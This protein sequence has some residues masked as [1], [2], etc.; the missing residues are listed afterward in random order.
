[1]KRK[2][3][4]RFFSFL[5]GGFLFAATG[6]S[7]QTI[8]SRETNLAS[9]VSGPGF[10]NNVDQ[11]LQNP[12]GIAFQPRG[13]FFI[14][15]TAS[16]H[17]SVHDAN[18]AGARPGSFILPKP[19]A[20]RPETPTGIVADAS[21]FLEG[22]EVFQPFITATEDGDI[23]VWGTDS[24]GD[25]PPNATLVV[26]HSQSGAVYTGLAILTPNCC[27]PFLGVANFHSGQIESFTARFDLLAPAGSFT[28]PNLPAGF[29]PYGMQ[30][31]GNQLFI[32]YAVQDAAKQNPVFGAGNG[33]VSIFDLAGNFQRRFATGGPLNAPWGITQA[34]PNFGPFRND[35]LIGNF[36][37]GIVNAFDPATGAFIGQI[38]DGDGNVIVNEGLHGL[39]FRPDGF[40]DRNTL[41]FTAGI[42]NGLDG[43]FGKITPGLVSTTR[44]SA[45]PSLIS[46][47][48]PITVT[49]SAGP[50]NPGTPTGL[51][52]VND[53]GVSI[54]DVGITN[55]VIVFPAVL[56]AVGTHIFEAKYSGDATFLPSSSQT[57]VQVTGAATQL[58]LAA[59]ATA[60]PGSAVTLTASLR[61]GGGTPTGLI[62]FHDGNVSLGSAPLNASGVAI[63][64]INTLAAGNHTLTASYPGDGN[65]DGSTSE[66][67]IIAIAGKDFSLGVAPPSATVTAGQSA[68][69]TLTVTPAQGFA[70][71]VTFSCPVLTGITCS[72]NPPMVT[73]NAGAATTMLTVTTSAGVTHYGRTLN[74]NGSGL[75]LASL[76][77]VGILVSLKKKIR[78]PH[79]AFLRIAAGGL[80]VITLA[81]TLI[82]CGG[83]TTS[84]QTSRGT[85]SIA[86]TAQSGAISHT[87]NVSVT[88]Q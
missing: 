49:V 75:L 76:G 33:I 12:W 24:N 67:V 4:W 66:A 56:T 68:L 11:V 84:G 88:V 18:G 48:V 15:D 73:P 5:I 46:T 31:I 58:N 13:S 36:G 42:N 41:Y 50:G 3:A 23:F 27:A 28:D 2:M 74:T 9:D 22:T 83:Y 69:F 38:Q 34:G 17:V 85:A 87:A 53:G 82:S 6:S 65:F 52:A 51:V 81:L 78:S 43:L 25:F 8:A 30:V 59:P 57:E 1:M 37:D 7:A 61:S 19:G 62:V 26:N 80:A 60:T 10:A 35:I 32:T 72:F 77:L 21:S 29:A 16:G 63:L 45:P 47:P 40:D 70:D 64:R 20:D 86:V 79:A 14:A 44:V 39:T 71:P 55:G 54:A